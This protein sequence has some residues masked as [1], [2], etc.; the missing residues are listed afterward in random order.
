MCR[1]YKKSPERTG[2]LSGKC[3]TEPIREGE[4]EGKGDGKG[5][6][7]EGEYVS[8]EIWHKARAKMGLFFSRMLCADRNIITIIFCGGCYGSSFI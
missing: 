2:D 7:W 6:E 8:I 5:G 4:W 3:V 1:N